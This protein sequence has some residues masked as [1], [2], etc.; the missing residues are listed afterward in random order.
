[1]MP[2][3]SVARVVIAAVAAGGLLGGCGG[4][5][6]NSSTTGLPPTTR[7][8]PV[9]SQQHHNQADVVFLQNMILHHSQAITMCDSAHAKATSLRVKALALRIKAAQEQEIPQMRQL[10][11]AW[12]AAVPPNGTGGQMPGMA[13][14]QQMQQLTA[15]SGDEFDQ[16]FLRMMVAHHQGAIQ[17]SQT[18]LAQGTDPQARRLAQEIISRQQVEINQMQKLLRPS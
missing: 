18:E 12:D 2:M 5:A 9:A 7:A 17:M 13:S 6:P 11:V 8:A 10:L 15:S 1:M 4:T 14:D 16:M 3:Y